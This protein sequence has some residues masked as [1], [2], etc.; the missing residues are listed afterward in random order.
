[1]MILRPVTF[2]LLTLAC[3]YPAAAQPLPTTQLTINGHR[4]TAEVAST[5]ETQT[6]GLMRRFSLQP[7]HGML[8]VFRTP[9]PLAFWMKD[10][11]IP[12]SIAFI[13]ADGK[14]LNIE[15]MAPQT[16]STHLSRGPAIFALEMKKG[17]FAQRGIA[18]GDR[19]GGLGEALKAKQ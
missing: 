9:R 16:E 5:V 17:W 13:G 4:V 1:M 15:D 18:A 14:I 11:Y 8:F 7:D 12:L 3:A 2:I 6:I 10:T 19:V